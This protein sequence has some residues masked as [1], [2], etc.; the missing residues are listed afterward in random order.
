MQ[1]TNRIRIIFEIG[2]ILAESHSHLNIG[3]IKVELLNTYERDVPLRTIKQYISDLVKSFDMPLSVKRGRYGGYALTSE[4]KKRVATLSA[5]VLNE[6]QRNGINDAFEI[7]LR[8]ANFH[9]SKELKEA[10]A[11][12]GANEKWKDNDF[13]YYVGK[14][15]IDYKTTKNIIL[16][17]E[18]ISAKMVIEMNSKFEEMNIPKGVSL[19]KPLFIV[20]DQDETF[21]IGRNNNRDYIYQNVLNIKNIIIT[22]KHFSVYAEDDIKKHINDFSLKVKGEYDIKF[23]IKAERGNK[24]FTLIQYEFRDNKSKVLE[25]KHVTFFEKYKALEF[26][27][28]MNKYIEV[29][30]M[31]KVL[32]SEWNKKILSLKA[33]EIQ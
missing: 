2:K 30:E 15:N 6:E 21:V 23:K 9:Y 17:K 5:S 19:M 33:V 24:I 32:I 28:R 31:D 26:L 11:L 20:H 7:A 27:F 22:D 29:I 14:T 18:A 25:I 10:K 3:E 8:S 1:K 4:W 16:L 13:E 12:I